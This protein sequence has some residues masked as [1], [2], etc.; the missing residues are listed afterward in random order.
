MTFS[1]SSWRCLQ[2][3]AYSL[4]DKVLIVVGASSNS[5]EPILIA[6]PSHD[7]H[8][9]SCETFGEVSVAVGLEQTLECTQSAPPSNATYADNSSTWWVEVHSGD[10]TIQG[11]VQSDHGW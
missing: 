10:Q 1:V 3:V 8:N 9:I 5:P 11:R 2:G 7:S 6:E 4:L